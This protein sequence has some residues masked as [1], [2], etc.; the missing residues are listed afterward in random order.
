[1]ESRVKQE[2][3]HR[4]FHRRTRSNSLPLCGSPHQDNEGRTGSMGKRGEEK[5]NE[6]TK[7]W[8]GRRVCN[9]PL[10]IDHGPR[11]ACWGVEGRKQLFCQLDSLHLKN[12]RDRDMQRRE[13]NYEPPGRQSKA[14]RWTKI[15]KSALG[16]KNKKKY[17]NLWGW[18]TQ[19]RVR[20]VQCEKKKLYLHNY[21]NYIMKM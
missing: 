20:S 14:H 9:I 2:E 17:K 21:N 4:D 11:D 3:S 10:Q 15:I 18:I 19:K 16:N 6:R 1:M 5:K 12:L 13:I 8:K 7:A